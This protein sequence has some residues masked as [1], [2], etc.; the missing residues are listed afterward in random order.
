MALRGM[1]SGALF[2]RPDSQLPVT[3]N[4]CA[5][6]WRSRARVRSRLGRPVSRR[7][8]VS[9]GAGRVPK[10]ESLICTRCARDATRRRPRAVLDWV[11]GDLEGFSAARNSPPAFA[12]T[13][14]ERPPRGGACRIYK[15]ASTFLPWRRGAPRGR[16]PTARAGRRVALADHAERLKHQSDRADDGEHVPGLIEPVVIAL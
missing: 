3:G 15:D 9:R 7:C 16:A 4:C 8:E 12:A 1:P 2:V 10:D 14:L 11:A 13:T 6:R 5:I